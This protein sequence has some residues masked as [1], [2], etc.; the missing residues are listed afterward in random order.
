MSR[1]VRTKVKKMERRSFA[2]SAFPYSLTII[3]LKA[4][5]ALASKHTKLIILKNFIM[6]F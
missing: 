4:I 5:I 2:R 3:I 1:P 6:V